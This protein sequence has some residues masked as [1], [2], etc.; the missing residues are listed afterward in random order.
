[1]MSERPTFTQADV[2][3]LLEQAGDYALM[4]MAS[5]NT[6]YRW[7][8]R[9]KEQAFDALAKRLQQLLTEAAP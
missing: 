9:E 3:M 4:A 8:Y 7:K 2:S 1:M 6:E 5:K